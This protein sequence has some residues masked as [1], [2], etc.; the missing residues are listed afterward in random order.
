MPNASGFV[1]AS[2]GPPGGPSRA[3]DV[4]V[5]TREEPRVGEPPHVVTEHPGRERAVADDEARVLGRLRELPV[6]DAAEHEVADGAAP[7]PALEA[8]LVRDEVRLGLRVEALERLEP[9]DAR[10][11]VAGLAALLRVVEMSPEDLRVA[12]REAERRKP[13][14]PLVT[15]HGARTPRRASRAR[16]RSGAARGPG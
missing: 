14:Q 16:P 4:A 1:P 13:G 8:G 7:V 10:V 12:G 9:G 15:L 2:F 11:A 5:S 3:G 6:D